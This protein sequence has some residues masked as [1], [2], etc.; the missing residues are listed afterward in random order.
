MEDKMKNKR[1]L[2]RIILVLLAVAGL[3]VFGAGVYFRFFRD[4]GYA[5][6]EAVIEKIEQ[7]YAGEDE[8]G[9][10]KYD[11]EVYVRYTVD[12][13]EYHEKIADYESGFKEGKTITLLYNEND[14]LDVHTE[15]KTAGTVMMIAGPVVTLIILGFAVLRRFRR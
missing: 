1:M 14:P 15:S 12:G 7:I 3:A 11:Y 9:R 5:K 4:R 8:D 6:T 2:E 10:S 13:R